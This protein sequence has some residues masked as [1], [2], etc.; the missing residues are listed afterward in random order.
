MLF[1]E[2][3]VGDKFLGDC[4]GKEY[5][6]TIDFYV[7][8]KSYNCV[9]LDNMSVYSYNIDGEVVKPIK[10]FSDLKLGERFEYAG[11]SYI[12]V[13]WSQ[14][15]YLSY[16]AINMDTSKITFILDTAIVQ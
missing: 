4:S 14:N 13:Q 12:K 2:L 9:R 15:R 3:K 7:G 10:H 6:K 11:T 5:E 8:G 1:S 16:N